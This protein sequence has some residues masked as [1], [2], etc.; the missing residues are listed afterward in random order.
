MAPS[1]GLYRLPSPQL[2]QGSFNQVLPLMTLKRSEGGKEKETHFRFLLEDIEVVW[3]GV[4]D[5]FQDTLVYQ[6]PIARELHGFVR[7]RQSRYVSWS[8][9]NRIA[10]LFPFVTLRPLWIRLLF[11]DTTSS[12]ARGRKLW[13]ATF[14]LERVQSWYH[15]E[16]IREYEHFLCSR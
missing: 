12:E 16:W 13:S 4:D 5:T 7:R 10:S 6:Y 8:V 14:L 9:E 11:L 3:D 15:F 1:P 2:T